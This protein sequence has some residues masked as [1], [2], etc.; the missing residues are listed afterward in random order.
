MKKLLSTTVLLALVTITTSL[1]AQLK[2]LHTPKIEH[3]SSIIEWSE[4][5]G[6]L[7]VKDGSHYF[8]EFRNPRYQ[9]IK[10]R[11]LIHIGDLKDYKELRE[12]ILSI[13]GTKEKRTF[14]GRHHTIYVKPR[15]KKQ[16]KLGIYQEYGDDLYTH[17]F[18]AR[19]IKKLLPNI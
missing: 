13:V 6:S 18:S 10:D 19:Q 14:E 7:K 11:Q 16:I 2:E 9:Y 5:K 8:I 12:A 15:G 3:L 4:W 17:Y 1:S